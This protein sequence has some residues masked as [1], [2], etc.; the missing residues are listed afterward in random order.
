MGNNNRMGIKEKTQYIGGIMLTNYLLKVTTKGE[1]DFTNREARTKVGYLASIVGLI[2]NILLSIT[3]L[4]IGF[5]IS[6]IGVIADGFNNLSDA[7][8]SVITIIGFKLSNM[9]ADKEHPYGHG[10]LEYISALIVAFMVMMVGFQFVKSSLDKIINPQLV[11]FEFVPF[12][13]LVISISAKVWLSFFNK[14]LGD[15]INSSVLKATSIDAL[16]DVLTT[17]V[18]VISILIGKFTT[19]PVDGYIG[20]IVSVLI[21]YSGY[22]LVKETI[23]PLIG[24]APDEEL[25]QSIYKDVLSYD[26]I[27]GAHDLVIH[28]YGA[29]KTMATIDVEFPG[30]IDV[31]AIHDVIDSIE[32]ELGEKY[33]LTLVIHMDPLGHESKERYELRNEIKHIIKRIS[34]IKSMHDFHILEEGDKKTVEF[35]LVID[36]NKMDKQFMGE[37]LKNEVIKEIKK[38][39][40]D[41][42]C[43]IIIDIEY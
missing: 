20:I 26:Y 28:T 5:M 9:P 18:V 34:T 42:D 19:F 11:K 7:A 16:G 1:T 4:S 31:I 30:N 13:I 23:S 33:N 2:T 38:I 43:N 12:M 35:H 6:S 40:S 27:T 3:K 8:S 24:E 17:S 25:I 32:R 41:L 29:W 22:N 10:R 14:K 21:I 15:I 37:D 36:G 39:N